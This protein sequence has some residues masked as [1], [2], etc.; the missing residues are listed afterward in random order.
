KAT[1][2]VRPLVASAGRTP[3]SG[4]ALLSGGALCRSSVP[5]V[6]S[7][8][9]TGRQR[10]GGPDVLPSRS[11]ASAAGAPEQSRLQ[12]RV[13]RLGTQ[14]DGQQRPGEV[15]PGDRALHLAI[16]VHLNARV[17]LV[18]QG[19]ALTAL[20]VRHP[21]FELLNALLEGWYLRFGVLR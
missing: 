2:P 19:Q 10:W 21:P 9:R 8:R 1:V 13:R 11:G 15:L 7:R 6:V 3:A 17:R 14:P 4:V 12:A 18:G 16:D 5:A 20:H